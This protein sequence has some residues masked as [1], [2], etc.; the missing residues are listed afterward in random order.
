MAGEVLR[1][2][3]LAGQQIPAEGGP[4]ADRA[5]R[6]AFARA[7]RDMMQLPVDFVG[8]TLARVSLTELLDLPPERGLNLMLEGP[9]E[10]LGLLILSP[11]LLSA[12]VEVLTMGKCG[13]HPPDSRKPTRT[14]AA[15]LSPLVDLAMANLEEALAEEGD[16]IWTSGFRYASF[17]EEARS[18]G[19]L[20]EDVIYRTLTAR[21]SLAQGARVGEMILVLPAEGRGQKPRQKAKSVPGAVAGPAFSAALGA[22][23][24]DAACQL[25][26]VLARLAMPLSD[27][28]DLSVDAVLPLPTANLD[29]ISLEGLDGR[30]V[31]VGK[32][33]QHR[34]MR[35]IRVTHDG[36][37]T[38]DAARLGTDQAPTARQNLS[39]SAGDW[40]GGAIQ[41][42]PAADFSFA[43]F[44]ATGT[45]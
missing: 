18:L 19:L 20:L 45:E 3:L 4:G 31:S 35:A 13:A 14:D 27:V 34:G 36:T 11:D 29:R 41:T 6:L 33:G 30:R 1:K 16:L 17:I 12:F 24:E 26:A 2:K 42:D 23:V 44:S 22:Q 10:G 37:A 5:W 32:L 40:Q 38:G 9:E 21:L 28:M 15:M 25:E 7:A 39:N 43:G 8:L